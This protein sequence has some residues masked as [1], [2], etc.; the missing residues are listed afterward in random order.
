MRFTG[1]SFI[2][3]P[4]L[5]LLETGGSYS[6]IFKGTA[7][8]ATTCRKPTKGSYFGT[9]AP[10]SLTE[11]RNR[12]RLDEEVLLTEPVSFSE[13]RK[14]YKV[15]FCD[16]KSERKTQITRLMTH[17]W[18]RAPRSTKKRNTGRKARQRKATHMHEIHNI[19]SRAWG[20]TCCWLATV[21]Q[22]HGCTDGRDGEALRRKGHT[23]RRSPHRWPI[24]TSF[25]GFPTD[26]DKTS[27]LIH[28]MWR[29]DKVNSSL[30][31]FGC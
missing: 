11:D 14:S 16:Y 17:L 15:R 1:P 28:G 19:P 27:C 24:W 13:E 12:S 22:L 8:C 26:V 3:L 30:Y 4:S 25:I 10:L 9:N 29:A 18:G 20:C 7:V 5:V 2:V 23:P 6:R 31:L 21:R